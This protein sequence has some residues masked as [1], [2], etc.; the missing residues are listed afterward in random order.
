MNANGW[1]Y[2]AALT[3]PFL[4]RFPKSNILPEIAGTVILLPNF[5]FILRYTV[6]AYKLTSVPSI[7]YYSLIYSPTL[8]LIYEA[9]LK[10][11][12]AG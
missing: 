6:I 10:N 7:A 4:A 2:T 12:L 11:L 5:S 1:F 3:L 8:L 9:I